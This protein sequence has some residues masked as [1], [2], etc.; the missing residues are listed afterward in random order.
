MTAFDSFINGS[1][2]MIPDDH[3]LDGVMMQDG[4]DD[5]LLSVAAA[6]ELHEFSHLNFPSV[7][8]P[9]PGFISPVSL[10]HSPPATSKRQKFRRRPS[11]GGRKPD[12]C[13]KTSPASVS[14]LVTSKADLP[15]S[16]NLNPK[17]SPC[18]VS[19]KTLSS[20]FSTTMWTSSDDLGDNSCIDFP[21]SPSNSLSLDAYDDCQPND[22]LVDDGFCKG[23]ANLRLQRN[24]ATAGAV[25]RFAA[26]TVGTFDLADK[27]QL[28]E[29]AKIRPKRLV[30]DYLKTVA[31]PHKG[32][33]KR[34]RD[35]SAM[36]KHLH[37]HGPRVHVCP[38][39]EKAFVEASKL[40]R[41]QLVHTGE[42]PFKC[43]FEGC[44]KRFSLDFNLRTHVRIHTGDLHTCLKCFC[45]K[46]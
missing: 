2:L 25:K 31:C 35:N 21:C 20:E 28:A 18:L 27:K 46:L 7:D 14:S 44:G 45:L 43:T 15:M 26:S 12:R 40:R 10:M 29:F 3:N 6:S 38:E 37:T 39:C 23:D 1:Y 19:V 24:E 5:D 9:L 42:K 17:W 36:R 32:C 34:F 8:L 16:L 11:A 13:R 41:H 30:D 22:V 4:D 33:N